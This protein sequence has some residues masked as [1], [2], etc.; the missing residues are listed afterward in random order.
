M[1]HASWLS[2]HP[3]IFVQGDHSQDQKDV[4][5]IPVLVAHKHRVESHV[6]EVDRQRKSEREVVTD[7]VRNVGLTGNLEGEALVEYH[8]QFVDALDV[9]AQVER[10]SVFVSC[11][12]DDE[13]QSQVV[14][15]RKRRYFDRTLKAGSNKRSALRR[16]RNPD[17]R[18]GC[19]RY[20]RRISRTRTAGSVSRCRLFRRMNCD[21]KA[22][23][24]CGRPRH[25]S[26]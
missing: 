11:H 5:N 10:F 7:P 24:V 9:D 22:T 17:Q 23:A 3:S 15:E 14:L 2:P 25:H 19:L 12:P 16:Q 6:V 26:Y 20:S 18:S 1:V 8:Q 4:G 21:L 13:A